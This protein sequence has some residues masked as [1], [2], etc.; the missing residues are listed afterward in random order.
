MSKDII[1]LTGL[2]C[3]GKGE[4]AKMLQNSYD[5]ENIQVTRLVE[6]VALQ[7][8]GKTDRGTVEQTFAEINDDGITSLIFGK[9]DRSPHDLVVIDSIR[10]VNIL[11][12]MKNKYNDSFKLVT[13]HAPRSERLQRIHSRNRQG[14]PQTEEELIIFDRNMLGGKGTSKRYETL[15]CMLQKDALLKNKS[16]QIETLYTTIDELLHRLGIIR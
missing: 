1:G 4:V 14:D 7:R 5:A 3:V 8:Y 13:V 9:V 11:H 2:I 12:A 15:A 16:S 6:E 10:R